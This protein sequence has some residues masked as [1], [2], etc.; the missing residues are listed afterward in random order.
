MSGVAARGAGQG[1]PTVLRNTMVAMAVSLLAIAENCVSV[2]NK[3]FIIL[4]HSLLTH[5]R[6]S[7]FRG[8]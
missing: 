3:R 2:S 7:A 5:A 8:A 1:K 4:S 6:N